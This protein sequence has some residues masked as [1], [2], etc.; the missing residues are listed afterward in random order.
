[1]LLLVVVVA[2]EGFGYNSLDGLYFYE[3]VRLKP[4]KD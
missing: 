4:K 2:K 1:M 3:L